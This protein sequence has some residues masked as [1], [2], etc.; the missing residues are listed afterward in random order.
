[1]VGAGPSHSPAA[2]VA[3][4]RARMIDPEHTVLAA[5]EGDWLAPGL[6]IGV[7]RVKI[8]KSRLAL[9]ELEMHQPTRHIGN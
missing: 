1:M 4:E 9:E 8:R 2:A 5:V 7:R 3:A 6:K